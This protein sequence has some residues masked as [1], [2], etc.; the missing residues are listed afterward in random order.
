[1]A[2]SVLLAIGPAPARSVLFYSTG[3]P[4]RN[5]TAPTG[6][7]ANSG[8]DQQGFWGA[9]L[10]TPIAPRYFLTARH[11][12]GAA[13]GTFLFQGATYTTTGVAD[14]SESDLRIWQVDIPFPTYA[15]LYPTNDEVGR[16]LVVFGRG[17]QRGT[18]VWITA[19]ATKFRGW[20]WGVSDGR[21]R[22]GQNQVSSIADGDTVTGTTGSHLG[23]LLKALFN[24]GGGANEAQLSTGDSGGGVF[25]N[26]GVGWKL[27]GINY[28]ADGIYSFGRSDAPFAAALF[29][30]GGLY[31]V[32]GTNRVLI[33]N[34]P[35]AQPGAFYATRVSS[36]L[37]WI[38]SVV[39][40]PIVSGDIVLQSAANLTGPFSAEPTAQVDAVA[41]TVTGPVPSSIRYYRLI[42]GSETRITSE[43]LRGTN[44]VLSFAANPVAGVVSP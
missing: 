23:E 19:P 28:G 21:M 16:G 40:Q 2:A 34:L 27:A 33:P 24:A 11:V 42:A 36:H 20:Q 39:S 6:D 10:G 38:Q 15:Q 14:D 4:E 26:D 35:S 3:D 18:Q 25:I 13:G 8:W 43:T 7:L 29:D 41:G 22:W 1:M 17:T 9:F 5:T 37:T 31:T 32:D 30:Q 12:G 44:L